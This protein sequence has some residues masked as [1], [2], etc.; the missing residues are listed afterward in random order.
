MLGGALPPPAWFREAHRSLV[1]GN[2]LD[3]EEFLAHAL[4]R[5][6]SRVD[7]VEQPGE[8]AMRGEVADIW[9]PGEEGPA[10]ILWPFDQ[11]E[12]I[13]K[14]DMTTQRSSD[15]LESL[16]VKPATLKPPEGAPAA[17]L[18]DYLGEG[19]TLYESNLP[20]AAAAAWT[21]PRVQ[22]IE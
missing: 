11:L 19:G 5:G 6:Y 14:I 1:L 22:K 8:L 10:R 9:P 16:W 7:T 4:R 12:S 15:A 3:R 20:P 13:R 18:L 17:S 2:R 21:G